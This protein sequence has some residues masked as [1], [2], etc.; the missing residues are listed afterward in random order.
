MI[1]KSTLQVKILTFPRYQNIQNAIL[2]HVY[3]EIFS[4]TGRYQQ[5]I[6]GEALGSNLLDK[7]TQ[8][9]GELQLVVI[10]R[11]SSFVDWKSK[12]LKFQW[13]TLLSIIETNHR[14]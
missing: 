8:F 3:S 14:K 5:S 6:R 10:A 4:S 12:I 11:L 1:K 9:L 2:L 13:K 7:K